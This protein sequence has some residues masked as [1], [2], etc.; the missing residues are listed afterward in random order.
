MNI[1]I[2]GG[3]GAM[4]IHLVQLLSKKGINTVVTS[5]KKRQSDA[6]VKYRQGDSQDINF[7]KTILNEN[8]WDA[9]VDFM[10]YPT[11]T[12]K[13]RVGFLLDATSQYVFL[14]SARV[15]A[16]SEKPIVE[17]SSRLLDDSHDE[18]YLSTDEYALSKARQEDLLR[19]SGKK[20]WTIIRPYITYSENRLQLGVLEK[21]EWLYRALHGR[22]IVFSKDIDKHITTLTYGFDVAKGIVELIGNSRAIGEVFHITTQESKTWHEILD[23]YLK[24]LE[25]HLG[26][27]PKVFLQDLDSFLEFKPAKF[28]ILYDRFYNRRFDNKKIK[29]YINTDDFMEIETGL[30]SCLQKFLKNPNFRYINWKSEALKDRQTKEI[31]KLNEFEG[32]K[33]M[34]YYILYRYII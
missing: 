19:N 13:D 3:T 23:I 18:E 15:Y 31:T 29:K 1:L 14:S 10:V 9:I 16:D 22:S 7:L 25:K 28:Q 2:L 17:K 12:F 21:E 27:T 24:V 4:G 5:R 8:K 11:H 6:T 30:I 34:L 20:N 33:Q 32:F 26:Y